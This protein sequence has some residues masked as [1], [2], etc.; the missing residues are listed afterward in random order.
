MDAE[1]VVIVASAGTI[2][3]AYVE[4]KF[5]RMLPVVGSNNI[6][7][8]AVGVA[9]AVGGWYLKMDGIADALEGFGLGWAAN[10]VLSF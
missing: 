4:N 5:G 10:A 3:G 2:A 9:I 6:A 1:Q 8:A 7:L